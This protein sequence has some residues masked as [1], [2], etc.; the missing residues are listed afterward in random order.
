MPSPPPSP[1]PLGHPSRRPAREICV[2]PRTPEIDSTEARLSSCAL[3]ATIGGTRPVV[4]I[5]QVGRLLEE[6]HAMLPGD[7]KVHRFEPEDFIVEFTSPTMADRVLHAYLPPEAPFQ[8]IWK[9]WRRQFMASWAPLRFKVL[10]ELRGIPGHA[11]NVHTAQIAL[12]MACSGLVQAPDELAGDNLRFLHVAAWCVHPDLIPA[13]KLMFIPEPQDTSGGGNLFLRPEEIIHSKH[14]GLWYRVEIRILEVQDWADESSSSSSEDED[15]PGFRQRHR[16]QP[17]P[18]SHHPDQSA[19]GHGGLALGP[20]WGPVFAPAMAGG[21]AGMADGGAIDTRTW[22]LDAPLLFGRLQLARR[23]R[24][25]SAPDRQ[26]GEPVGEQPLAAEELVGATDTAGG[27]SVGC[28]V[29]LTVPPPDPP[30][31]KDPLLDFPSEVGQP[32]EIVS[33]PMLEEADHCTGTV[34]RPSRQELQDKPARWDTGDTLPFDAQQTTNGGEP[35][36]VLIEVGSPGPSSVGPPFIFGPQHADALVAGS[37]SRVTQSGSFPTPVENHEVP[38]LELETVCFTDA[39]M[40][41]L[42]SSPDGHAYVT[43]TRGSSLNLPLHIPEEACTP[44]K[45]NVAMFASN[46]CRPRSPAVLRETPPRRRARTPAFGSPLQL[47]RS[48]RLAKKSRH[49]AT[50]PALQAQNVL[51]KKLGISSANGPPDAAA[52]QKYVEVFHETVTASQ[53]EAMDA[54]LPTEG[55]SFVQ[56]WSEVEP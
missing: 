36:P 39:P 33:D 45:A 55:P 47:R 28:V 22:S 2:V 42:P 43:T 53:C 30:R 25:T 50:K 38:L 17:W 10:V 5:A 24:P 44:V 19:Q 14:D 31:P 41:E 56:T 9:Q 46:V 21:N 20:G 23:G 6:F 16:R 32:R 7:Y 52:F 40:V 37:P 54:I 3:V 27:Q 51:M 15:Y 29:E 12:G 18:R 13:E 49:R 8:L 4:H 1:R 11:R 26:A 35:D 34:S 48:E